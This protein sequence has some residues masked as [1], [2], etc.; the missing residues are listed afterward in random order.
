[1]VWSRNVL[2]VTVILVL[3]VSMISIVLYKA[4]I[5]FVS[6]I[7][8]LNNTKIESIKISLLWIHRFY[9]INKIQYW[10]KNWKSNYLINNIV[11]IFMY[12][13][14]VTVMI[15]RFLSCLKCSNLN[16]KFIIL[17]ELFTKE[18]NMTI[19][20]LWTYARTSVFPSQMSWSPGL[21]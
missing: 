2:M 11:F 12:T 10:L 7:N 14:T 6:K 18:Q 15:E 4:L 5:M 16:P 8:A 3:N 21:T 19:C 9:Y 20:Q 17:D 13:I 1:M